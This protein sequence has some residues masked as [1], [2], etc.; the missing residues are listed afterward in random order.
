MAEIL[1]VQTNCDFFNF[2]GNNFPS[3]SVSFEEG[4]KHK[5]LVV[6]EVTHVNHILFLPEIWS[7]VFKDG[8][9]ALINVCR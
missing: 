5:L 7:F 8:R 4:A 1:F 3:V 9:R 6:M 2:N